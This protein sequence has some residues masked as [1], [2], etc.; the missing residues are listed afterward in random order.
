MGILKMI[1]SKLG[2]I[3][4][5]I[6]GVLGLWLWGKRQQT[7]RREAEAKLEVAEKNIEVKKEEDKRH[8]KVDSMSPDELVD[9]WRGKRL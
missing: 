6:L 2:V 1:F 5:T 8:E 3:T 4:G 7:K 9:Y